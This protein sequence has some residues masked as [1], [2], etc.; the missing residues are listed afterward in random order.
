MR[1][2]II[3]GGVAGSATAVALRRAGADVTVYEAYA[4]P[5]G[6]PTQNVADWCG[7]IL[8]WTGNDLRITQD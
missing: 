4:D 5:A 3:G 1:V 6:A 8:I 2:A 7:S